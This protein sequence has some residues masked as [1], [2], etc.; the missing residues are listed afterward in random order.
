VIPVP[1]VGAAV[2]VLLWMALWWL[3]GHRH[4]FGMVGC[5]AWA[6]ACGV[7]ATDRATQQS[8]LAVLWLALALGW[9]WSAGCAFC[10][11]QRSANPTE[12]PAHGS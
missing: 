12:E 8:W 6:A 1:I 5:L 3:A 7:L 11:P 10:L 9:A 4:R 2:L